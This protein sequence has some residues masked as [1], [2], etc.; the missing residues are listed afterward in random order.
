M[1]TDD[2]TDDAGYRGP[3]ELRLIICI[4]S[5]PAS[6][7]GWWVTP[8]EGDLPLALDRT[9]D[10]SEEMKT[11]LLNSE[12]RLAP[13]Y[14]FPDVVIEALEELPLPAAFEG[15]GWLASHRALVLH[16]GGVEIGGALLRYEKGLGLVAEEEIA[17]GYG[18]D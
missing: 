13:P 12:I 7:G 1:T 4:A 6:D 14:E 9:V 2:S 18:T 11:A 16:P 3:A 8:L 5:E 10:L 17:D 15:V